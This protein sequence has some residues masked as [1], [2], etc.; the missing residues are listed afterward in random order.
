MLLTH[1]SCRVSSS[2]SNARQSFGSGVPLHLIRVDVVD[3]VLVER[4]T[5]VNVLV[6]D[7]VV[8][9]VTVVKDVVLELLV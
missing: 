7:V 3:A 9:T 2:W 6:A 5:E 1:S 8:L 4:V